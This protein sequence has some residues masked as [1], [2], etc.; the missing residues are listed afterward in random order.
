MQ[1]LH[2]YRNTDL[3]PMDAEGLAC[4][5]VHCDK[6]DCRVALLPWTYYW[7]HNLEPLSQSSEDLS[8]LLLAAYKFDE[9]EHFSNVSAMLLK[10]LTLDTRSKW[11]DH[12]MLSLL[13]ETFSSMSLSQLYKFSTI[14]IVHRCYCHQNPSS[15]MYDSLPSPSCYC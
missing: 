15:I 14:L 4:L 13:P 12:E 3:K 1:V 11:H 2:Y 8:F 9:R 6:Y 10:R 5:A 7:F